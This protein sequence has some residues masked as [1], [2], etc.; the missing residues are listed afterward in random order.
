MFGV[1]HCNRGRGR[2]A[3]VGQG[4]V[5]V[6]RVRQAGIQQCG[7]DRTGGAGVGPDCHDQQGA[8]IEQAQAL[9]FGGVAQHHVAHMTVPFAQVG[10]CAGV[11][12]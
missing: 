9:R 2:G 7:A 3:G 11:Q 6:D 8:R 12:T 5:H 10:F 1:V 4:G